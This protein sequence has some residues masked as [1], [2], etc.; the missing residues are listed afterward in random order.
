[1]CGA[2]GV[3]AE[4]GGVEGDCGGG[5]AG[6]LVWGGEEGGG[7]EGDW[8]GGGGVGGERRGGGFLEVVEMGWREGWGVYRGA[9]D[10]GTEGV[11]VVGFVEV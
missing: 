5:G 8:E 3:W 10:L 9:L 2:G 1:M 7:D 6:E 11:F 4:C